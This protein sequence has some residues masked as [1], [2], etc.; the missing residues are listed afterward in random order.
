[1]SEKE[2]K[3]QQKIV[4]VQKKAETFLINSILIGIWKEHMQVLQWKIQ[5]IIVSQNF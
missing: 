4:I 1:M 5:H 2:L 3:K